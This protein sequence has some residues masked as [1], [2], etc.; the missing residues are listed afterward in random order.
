MEVTDQARLAQLAANR[1]LNARNGNVANGSAPGFAVR[2]S[3][4]TT[5]RAVAASAYASA[6]PAKPIA[7]QLPP[8][9][10]KLPVEVDEL[11]PHLSNARELYSAKSAVAR[12]AQQLYGTMVDLMDD[13]LNMDDS[14][15]EDDMSLIEE[16]ELEHEAAVEKDSDVEE[17]SAETNA[18][19]TMQVAGASLDASA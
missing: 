8:S 13:A 15:M 16:G 3:K 7:P 19:E 9:F 12:N 11:L 18:G 2:P 14:V 1:R 17:S 4:T 6:K 10:A 5:T